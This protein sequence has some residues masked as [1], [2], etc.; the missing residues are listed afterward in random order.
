MKPVLPRICD[1]YDIR[2]PSFHLPVIQ[3]EFAEQL[4]SYQITTMLNEN[5]STYE[6]F[7]KRIYTFFQWFQLLS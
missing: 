4:L 2:R 7:I 1:H 5:G 6:V 3:H